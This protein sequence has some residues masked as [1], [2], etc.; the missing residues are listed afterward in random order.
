MG[1]EGEEEE[2]GLVGGQAVLGAQVVDRAVHQVLGEVVSLVPRRPGVHRGRAVEELGVPV[3]HLA[4]EEPVEVLEPLAGGPAREGPD[5]AD[6]VLGGVVVLAEGRGA[7]PVA[8]QDLRER[9][10]AGRAHPAVA[11]EVR[12]HLRGHRHPDRV[13][14]PP[15]HQGLARRRAHGVDVEPA[16]GQALLGQALGGGHAHRAPV[17]A[18]GAEAHVVEHDD[19]HVGGALGRAHG[20]DRWRLLGLVAVV[21]LQHRRVR[22]VQRTGR[23][24]GQV[25]PVEGAVLAGGRT[26]HRGSLS[27]PGRLDGVALVLP[28]TS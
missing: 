16:V 11:G 20:A 7:V 1:A 2:E 22:G 4:R 10:G 21:V 8:A 23:A 28:V 12:G 3:V 13:V 9:A 27:S 24:G 14:V 26:V 18:G 6:L 5:G 15:R 25:R 17:D 19:H